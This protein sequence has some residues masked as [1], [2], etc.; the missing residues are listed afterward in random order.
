MTIP[1][2]RRV[3]TDELL[4]AKEW[5]RT[6]IGAFRIVINREQYYQ[7]QSAVEWHNTIDGNLAYH[8]QDNL[9][10]VG[11]FMGIGVYLDNSG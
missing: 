4:N 9:K 8:S 11:S 10:Y 7:M 2:M 5:D 3:T 6:R 1:N